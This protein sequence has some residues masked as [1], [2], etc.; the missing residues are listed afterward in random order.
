ML[1]NPYWKSMIA[2]IVGTLIIGGLAYH[3]T[4]I[5]QGEWVGWIQAVGSVEAIIASIFIAQAQHWTE[6]QRQIR[7]DELERQALVLELYPQLF[8]LKRWF[9]ERMVLDWITKSGDREIML[10]YKDLFPPTPKAFEESSATRLLLLPDPIGIR[11]VE[12]RELLRMLANRAAIFMHV[13]P[14]M[15][16][17]HPQTPEN[18]SHVVPLLKGLEADAIR[19]YEDVGALQKKI[20]EK[21]KVRHAGPAAKRQAKDAQL[22]DSEAKNSEPSYRK[23]KLWI[24]RR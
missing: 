23:A 15:Q 14:P 22:R 7:A 9:A 10:P 21:T 19:L 17:L 12:F 3:E 2:M 16:G 4:W 6:T 13:T 24:F 11:A 18:V 20:K 1:D 8:A 5:I